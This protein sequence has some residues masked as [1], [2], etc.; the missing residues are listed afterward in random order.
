[1]IQKEKKQKFIAS[2]NISYGIAKT[3]VKALNVNDA[4]NQLPKKALKNLFSLVDDQG[5][6]YITE[7]FI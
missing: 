5:H 6:D 4:I 3:E 7:L 2:Y 1:M